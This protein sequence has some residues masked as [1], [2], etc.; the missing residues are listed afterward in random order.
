[1]LTLTCDLVVSYLLCQIFKLCSSLTNFAR[2]VKYQWYN[3]SIA[4]LFQYWC[5]EAPCFCCQVTMCLDTIARVCVRFKRCLYIDTSA[6]FVSRLAEFFGISRILAVN[7]MDSQRKF[8]IDLD[9]PASEIHIFAGVD[10]CKNY[11]IAV[12]IY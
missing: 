4:P 3:H 6:V 1:M 12:A 9:Q 11:I 10:F 2:V 8:I 7:F 5:S